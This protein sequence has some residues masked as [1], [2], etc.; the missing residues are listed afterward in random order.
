MLDDSVRQLASNQPRHQ[1]EVIVM[2]KDE[3]PLAT[4]SRFTDDLLREQLVDQAVALGPGTMRAVVQHRRLRQVPQVVLHEPE[5]R[6]GDRVVV[7]VVDQPRRIDPAHL[8]A[9]AVGGLHHHRLAAV[10]QLEFAL[11]AVAHGG[12]PDRPRR[13]RQSGEPGDEPARAAHEALAFGRIRGQVDRGPVGGHDRVEVLEKAPGVLLDRQHRSRLTLRGHL[14][15][16]PPK[17]RSLARLVN[18]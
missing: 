14:P 7:E 5:Q 9:R 4:A 17:D 3:W 11:E 18:M 15:I 1:V 10:A 8:E 13:L 2:G 12:D 16:G 6:V